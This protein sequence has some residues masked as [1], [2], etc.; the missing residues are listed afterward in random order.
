MST[1]KSPHFREIY[2]T[3]CDQRW[4]M[5]RKRLSAK[6]SSRERRK[7][8]DRGRLCARDSNRSIRSSTNPGFEATLAGM[9]RNLTSSS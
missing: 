5:S 9:S 8:S 4:M 6:T 7:R 3:R 1:K 2:P